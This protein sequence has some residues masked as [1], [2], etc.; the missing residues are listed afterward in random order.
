MN[1]PASFARF[2]ARRVD[3]ATRRRWQE[4]Q[5]T[6][7]DFIWPLFLVAGRG[8]CRAIAAMPGVFHYSADVACDQVQRLAAHGL[9]AVLVFGVPAVKGLDQAWA[10]DGLVQTAVRALRAACPAVEVIT[11]VCV[12]SYTADGHCHSGDNDATCALLARIAVSHACAG[13]H[14]VAPSDMMDGRV[15]HIRRALDAAALTTTRILSYAAKYASA[16]YGPFRSAADC[17]PRMG[18][19]R[20]YQMDPPNAH[21]AL[22]E[23]KA[24]VDEGAAA[25]II[26][27]ALAYLDIIWRAR[28]AVACPVVAYNVSG[29]YVM[30]RQ[31]VAQGV[32]APRIIPETLLG[33]KRAGADRIISYFTPDV[34]TGAL[35]WD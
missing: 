22:E 20:T 34:L 8:E 10:D 6:A 25:V 13:A 11:D 19:R 18:D 28:Q 30:L 29:E 33:I 21:E 15:W 16:Y 35:P 3:A 23:I 5:L 26:K 31:A 14:T 4:T 2:R 24:D 17:A 9:R 7:A 32:A 27:P 12:C 1:A